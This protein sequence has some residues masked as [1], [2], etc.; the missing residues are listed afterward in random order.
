MASLVRC[1]HC[2]PRPKEEFTVRGAA[3]KRPNPEADRETWFAYVYLRENPQGLYE[4]YWHHSG[5]CHRWLIV[6]RNT[7]THEQIDVHDVAASRAS[8]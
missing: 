7:L 2:G 1:P 5:G 3:L 8:A 4:E 6:T